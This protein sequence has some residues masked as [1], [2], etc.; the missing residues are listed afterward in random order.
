MSVCY[1]GKTERSRTE[2]RITMAHLPSVLD[3]LDT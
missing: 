2:I 1:S 3:V